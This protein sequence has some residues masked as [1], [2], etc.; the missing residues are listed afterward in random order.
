[1]F[2]I[3]SCNPLSSIRPPG[4]Q[5]KKGQLMKKLM[6]KDF[7]EILRKG[8]CTSQTELASALKNAGFKNVNQ[9]KVSRMLAKAGAVRMPNAYGEYV[10]SLPSHLSA[11]D[12]SS[13]LKSLVI[14]IHYNSHL[15]VALTSP[16]AA[17]LI[18]RTLDLHGKKEGI[19]GTIA[20]DDTI[21]I[22][23]TRGTNIHELVEKIKREYV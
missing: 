13:S 18:A 15:I 7:L 11:P 8:C 14:S 5:T 21:F 16:G 22:T 3:P 1:M 17:Q 23:P 6:E 9:S 10:Y 12:I 2:C 19:L 20:G 4:M